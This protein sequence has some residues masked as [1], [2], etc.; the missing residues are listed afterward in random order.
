ME[1][2]EL[3][4]SW[5][6]LD[7]HLK[8]KELIKEDELE[9]LIG[10]ADKGIHAIARLNIRLI[11]ISLPILILFLTEVILHNRLNPIYII[12]LLAWIPALCW[13]IATTRFLQRTQIDEMPLVEVIARVNRIHHWTIRERLIATAFLLILAI[14]SFVYWQIWQYGIG[15]ILFFILLWGGGLI[16]ILWIYRKKFLN[17]IHEIKKNLS[18]LNEL[19]LIS[20]ITKDTYVATLI[21]IPPTFSGTSGPLSL[22]E[23]HCSSHRKM[24]VTRSLL[25]TQFLAN[26]RAS[27]LGLLCQQCFCG[28]PYTGHRVVLYHLFP[29]YSSQTIAGLI[30]RTRNPFS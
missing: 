20:I 26:R 24:V 18:E 9:R 5:N 11:L 27:L 19:M 22:L 3:K 16:L 8:D 13:D 21:Y 1:L 30:Y 28:T 12:I 23:I 2:E 25:G 7:E 10:H 29:V 4:K 14:L 6:A 15:M 17:R